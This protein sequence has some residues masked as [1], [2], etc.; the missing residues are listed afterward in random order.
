M[1]DLRERLSSRLR[2]LDMTAS[3][4]ARR[5]GVN[6]QNVQHWMRRGRIPGTNIFKVA[7]ELGC[8]VEWLA[9]G[10]GDEAPSPDS[11]PVPAAE[12]VEVPY[13]EDAD[14]KIA[15]PLRIAGKG[16]EDPEHLALHEVHDSAMS[17]T[18]RPGSTVLLDTTVNAPKENRIMV[19]RV[20]GQLKMRRVFLRADH[21]VMLSADN[22]D[23]RYPEE[24]IPP[25]LVPDVEWCGA[26][27]M[28]CSVVD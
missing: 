12:Y 13:I 3:E 7:E 1:P 18:V 24:L 26:A 23:R 27:I 8:N 19:M 11:I 2:Q 28:V 15:I 22:D 17:P 10:R 25:E 16:I 21:S 5:V 14:R 6:P 4:L 9:T 20:G